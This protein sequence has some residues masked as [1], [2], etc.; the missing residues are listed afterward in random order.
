MWTRQQFQ[1]LVPSTHPTW[2]TPRGDAPNCMEPQDD[3]SKCVTL[4]SL[5]NK[6]NK[7]GESQ[8]QTNKQR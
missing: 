5:S 1:V 4:H 7:H 6:E 3:L 8:S 2:L